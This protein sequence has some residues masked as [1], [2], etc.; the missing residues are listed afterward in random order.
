VR[1]T[2]AQ[3]IVCYCNF[4]G[5]GGE[6]VPGR[7]CD[8]SASGACLFVRRRVEPGALVAVELINGAHTFLCRRTFRVR[9][10]FPGSG[11]GSVL[12]GDFDRKLDYDELLPFI[13]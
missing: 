11:N 2:P 8:I 10:V 9:R 12:G 13:L 6:Y 5:P 3:E 7:V 4:V 1:F